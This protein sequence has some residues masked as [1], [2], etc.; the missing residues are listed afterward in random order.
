MLTSHGIAAH[1][2]A[3]IQH[4]SAPLSTQDSVVPPY[5][6]D[7]QAPFLKIDSQGYE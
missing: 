6:E 2:S 4:G 3:H 5:L 1:E 7:A